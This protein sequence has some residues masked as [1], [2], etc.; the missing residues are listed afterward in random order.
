MEERLNYL[1]N[2]KINSIINVLS[3]KKD[4]DLEDIKEEN[5]NQELKNFFNYE[6]NSDVVHNL[7]EILTDL[8]I[9][10]NH[11]LF[12]FYY[13]FENDVILTKNLMYNI[14]V[15]I[16]LYNKNNIKNLNRKDI[17]NLNRSML[18]AL[19][20]EEEVIFN[21]IKFFL[22]RDIKYKFMG[23][24]KF[25]EFNKEIE[26]SPISLC[27]GIKFKNL[28]NKN[29]KFLRKL[30]QMEI[31]SK[32]YF[33]KLILNSIVKNKN[34]SIVS[35]KTTDIP[36]GY[37]EINLENIKDKNIKHKNIIFTYGPSASGKS[38]ISNNLIEIINDICFFVDGGNIRQF[39]HVYKL[40]KNCLYTN[41]VCG[42]EF[43]TTK[44]CLDT[45]VSIFKGLGD[46]VKKDLFKFVI[47]YNM[48]KT[49]IIPS[50]SNKIP[51]KDYKYQY[52]R[53][54]I[55][56][57]MSKGA[58]KYAGKKREKDEGKIYTGD[59]KII[60]SS[61][62]SN[63]FTNWDK[64]INVLENIEASE[65]IKY[66]IFNLPYE[67]IKMYYMSKEWK[68]F[69]C[70]I[71]AIP[72]NVYLFSNSLILINKLHDKYDEHDENKEQI[73]TDTLK[74][75]DTKPNILIKKNNT[76]EF[77]KVYFYKWLK[78]LNEL[79]KDVFGY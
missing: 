30:F 62:I 13:F 25:K 22:D 77:D 9:Y 47:D 29:S 28:D 54:G 26:S 14:I 33:I 78:R 17:F 49:I 66:F 76:K 39:S 65:D 36:D 68:F 40:V 37:E 31:D 53:L 50:T 59:K 45:S 71:R 7:K 57:F 16:C 64:S 61:K 10:N 21:I 46:K 27:N 35:K 74:L 3:C 4:L 67:I 55:L 23:I 51:F 20:N 12:Y 75:L 52:K 58:C 5:L 1:I 60:D 56:I 32:E 69:N 44:R 34:D 42:Y 15:L 11:N 6:L 2:K 48:L 8:N 41:L 19:N 72:N 43:K 73:F 70:F 79:D 24:E 63:S 18:K 38:Y